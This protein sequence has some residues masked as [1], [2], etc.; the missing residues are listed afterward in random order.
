MEIQAHQFSTGPA[1]MRDASGATEPAGPGFRDMLAALN[2]LQ[3]LPV[4]GTIYR[5][6][7]GDVPHPAAQVVGGLLFGGPIGLMLGA[8]AATFEQATGKT[9]VQMAMD[10]LAPGRADPAPTTLADALMPADPEPQPAPPPA[11]V[12]AHLP[13]QGQAFAAAARAAAPAPA[14]P[15][16]APDPPPQ[17]ARAEDMATRPR[18]AGGRDLAFYQA[19]AGAR[20]PPA[21]ATGTAPV[22][23]AGQPAG[24][25]PPRLLPQA[26]ERAR[27]EAPAPARSTPAAAPA[28]TAAAPSPESPRGEGTQPA[29]PRVGQDFS[30]RML[31]GLERYRAMS[32]G[33]ELR[34]QSVTLAP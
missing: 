26:S 25:T 4:I 12:A 29:A 23:L 16:R 34:G 13:P 6:V 27:D 18:I 5:H 33:A 20:L 8:L 7:T 21:G 28:P 1:T 15:A 31:E 30:A 11:L 32:R 9:P 17:P 22:Q 10:A 24:L 19:H 3:G 2:P 14:R